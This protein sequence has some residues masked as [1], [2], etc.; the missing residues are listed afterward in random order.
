MIAWGAFK[1]S[2]IA[3]SNY[4]TTTFNYG[5]TFDNAIIGVNIMGG[6]GYA[7]YFATDILKN[8]MTV[9][10]Q[11]HKSSNTLTTNP[12]IVVFGY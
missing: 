9:G 5:V 3:A 11:N 8:S 10:C 12:T 2:N 7:I 4:K 6:S 1:L